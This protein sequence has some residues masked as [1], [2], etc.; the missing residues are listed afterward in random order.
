MSSYAQFNPS[1]GGGPSRAYLSGCSPTHSFLSLQKVGSDQAPAITI[2][3][4]LLLKASRSGKRF[5]YGRPWI[6][7]RHSRDFC[8]TLQGDSCHR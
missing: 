6:T 2:A 5:S 8:Q 3:G 7:T 4:P 1:Y